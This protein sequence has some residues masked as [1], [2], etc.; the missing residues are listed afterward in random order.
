MLA[1]QKFQ[2]EVNQYQQGCVD[3]LK[4][5][6]EVWETCSNKDWEKYFPV[7]KGN[8]PRHKELLRQIIKLQTHYGPIH[9]GNIKH[10]AELPQVKYKNYEL[11]YSAIWG[12]TI[13]KDG[14]QIFSL[15]HCA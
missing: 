14:H 1:T 15:G 7:H 6:I 5:I 2:L 12:Y 4:K 11:F 13:D 3:I 10:K 8:H 9:Y